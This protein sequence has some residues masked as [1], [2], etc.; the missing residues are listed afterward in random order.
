MTDGNI[1][2]RNFLISEFFRANGL[3]VTVMG[4]RDAP[5]FVT[6]D[7]IALSCFAHGFELVFRDDGFSGKEVFRAKLSSEPAAMED[8]LLEWTKT[9]KHRKI[10]LFTYNGMFF[11]RYETRGRKMP[12]FAEDKE[13][14]YYVFKRQKALEMAERFRQE[15]THLHVEM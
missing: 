15:N 7:N 9:A 3:E 11:S 14:A 4:R 1:K 10:Y 8:R 13:L 2:R 12:L 6:A 5:L